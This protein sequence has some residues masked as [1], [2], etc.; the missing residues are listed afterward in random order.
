MG[1]TIIS[2]DSPWE[3]ICEAAR[4]APWSA[5]KTERP[6][7]LTRPR[8]SQSEIAAL[9]GMPV[10]LIHEDTLPPHPRNHP[11][12]GP[13][14]TQYNEMMATRAAAVQKTI[15]SAGTVFEDF[16][17][18]DSALKIAN[19]RD[20]FTYT[21]YNVIGSRGARP[22]R[23]AGTPDKLTPPLPHRLEGDLVPCNA[24]MVT[25]SEFLAAARTIGCSERRLWLPENDYRVMSD[26][27]ELT[28]LLQLRQEKS[29]TPLLAQITAERDAENNA[30]VLYQTAFG[31][32]ASYAAAR[33]M[34]HMSC[35]FETTANY[36]FR[37][38]LPQDQ[39][40]R[41]TA[42][43][44]ALR[45]HA[46]YVTAGQTPPRFLALQAVG[47]LR[48]RNLS[49]KIT[50]MFGDELDEIGMFAKAYS[51]NRGTKGMLE[52]TLKGLKLM[53]ERNFDM[54]PEEVQPLARQLADAAAF[55]NPGLMGHDPVKPR[56][57][58]HSP[59]KRNG[60]TPA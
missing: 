32:S 40:D 1:K 37:P 6:S 53:S 8:L 45:L 30:M 38:G 35:Q 13:V 52:D 46:L 57:S 3:D 42:N 51:M 29:K 23:R 31:G 9:A 36:G 4:S 34:T 25:D 48:A 11:Q 26:A 28:H 27:H 5:E 56:I 20:H 43:T 47:H 49:A 54:L 12:I 24:I 15:M 18:E 14:S 19:N 60:A 10:L 2:Y 33:I 55:T 16:A 7:L 50:G 22:V 39:F 44:T 41:G 58:Y 17:D 21:Q 59:A